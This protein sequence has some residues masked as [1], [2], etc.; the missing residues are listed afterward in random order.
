M[1]DFENRL[2]KNATARFKWAARHG[3]TAFRVYDLDIPEWP[4]AV[5]WYG[6]L[7]HVMEYPSRR[8]LREGALAAARAEMK[9]A[10]VAALKVSEANVFTKLHEKRPGG[11]PRFEGQDTPSAIVHVKEGALTFECNLSDYLDAGLFLDHR[12]TRFEVAKTVRGKR[13]LNL[14]GYTGSFTVH[15]AAAGA[16]HTTTVDLS[17]TYCS[18]AER[19]LKLNQLVPGANHHIVCADVLQ[20]LEK[21][22]EQYDVVVVD[23]P[24]FSTSKK[25]GRRFEIQRDHLWLIETAKKRLR[26]G[27][28]LYFSTNFLRFELDAKLDGAEEL[29]WLPEDFR[30]AVHRAWRFAI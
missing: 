13:F 4:F 18:W 8:Q 6:G 17:P 27:G 21:T 3:L 12:R 26:P 28:T 25:M 11:L 5:D 10:V 2:R 15:A 20:W 7:V 30:R 19:N 14:F 24:S 22:T 29:H 23:P 16:A 9:R 1:S